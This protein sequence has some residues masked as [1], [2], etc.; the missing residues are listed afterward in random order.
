MTTANPSTSATLAV[1][2][3]TPAYWR[4]TL[5]N[6]P[7]NLHTAGMVSELQE[8]VNRLESDERVSVVVF[9]SADPD[10]FISHVD[11]Q[12]IGSNDTP[13][14][15]GLPP[16]PDVCTRLEHAP[17]VT[18]GL[19]RGRARGV[20]SEFL[21]ALDMRF[22]SKERA[23]LCQ[24]E[25]GFGFVPGGGGLE[26]LPL[27]TGR[28]RAMEIIVGGEDFDAD[29]AER[30]GWVNRSVPDAELDSFVER[31]ASRVAGFDRQA[32]T[33][34]KK[35]LN[36]RGQVAQ[37]TDQLET[38]KTFVGLLQSPSAQHKISE[39]LELGLQQRSDTEMNLAQVIAQL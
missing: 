34:A 12:E 5:N 15:S 26:R 8:L 33:T 7:I 9:D 32:V 2:E 24:P 19:I 39:L 25:I 31:L 4:V 36:Q 38:F 27:V 22:A 10:F 30:Y 35:I 17:C 16:W 37:G 6:P 20:G 11:V 18:V 21:L 29:T 23:I 14:P 13:G 1:T 28:S 3:V